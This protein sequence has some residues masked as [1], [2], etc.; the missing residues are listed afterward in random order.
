MNTFALPLYYSATGHHQTVAVVFYFQSKVN[1][2][3]V[4]SM[5]MLLRV[6]IAISFTITAHFVCNV[7]VFVCLRLSLSLSLGVKAEPASW[8]RL[9]MHSG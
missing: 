7:C 8:W 5:V 4:I 9:Y 2:Y 3:C 6:R 1:A